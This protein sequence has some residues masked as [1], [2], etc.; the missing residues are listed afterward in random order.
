MHCVVFG[1]EAMKRCGIT[2]ATPSQYIPYLSFLGTLGPVSGKSPYILQ[3]ATVIPIQIIGTSLSE[4]T[5]GSWCR[6]LHY[7]ICFVRSGTSI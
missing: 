6:D 7:N 2:L 3:P 4:P 1:R 5:L